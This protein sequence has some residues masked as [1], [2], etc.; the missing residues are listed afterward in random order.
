MFEQYIKDK[1]GSVDI[2]YIEVCLMGENNHQVLTGK[3][4]VNAFRVYVNFW[5]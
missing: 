3:W 1:I 4:D 2:D 5:K